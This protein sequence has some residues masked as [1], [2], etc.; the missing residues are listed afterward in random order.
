MLNQRLGA[1]MK[2]ARELQAAEELLDQAIQQF[3]RLTSTMLT[4]RQ[5]AG[6]S[7]AVGH[8]AF[9][10]V[11]EANA[12]IFQT[13]S[14]LLDTHYRLNE[15]KDDV[16]LRTMGYGTLQDCPPPKAEAE[17]SARSRLRSVG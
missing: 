7:A 1:A 2:V 17:T 14:K 5:D 8:A 13:R 10:S 12:L 11:A 4:A 16:G 6:V 3:T 15:A 9:D